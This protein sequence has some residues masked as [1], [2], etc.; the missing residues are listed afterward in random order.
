MTDSIAQR[1]QVTAS[2]QG[3]GDIM[4]LL[5]EQITDKKEMLFRIAATKPDS[6][7]GRKAVSMAAGAMAL[8]EFKDSLLGKISSPTARR[9]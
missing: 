5:D 2:T 4:S 1:L 8:I 3:W 6:L 9:D 7:T